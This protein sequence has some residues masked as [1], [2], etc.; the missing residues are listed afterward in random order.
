MENG[1]SYIYYMSPNILGPD[2]NEDILL[3]LLWL[4]AELTTVMEQEFS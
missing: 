4:N 1:L 2:Q 3:D